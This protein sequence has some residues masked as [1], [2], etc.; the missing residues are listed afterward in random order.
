[1]SL[2]IDFGPMLKTLNDLGSDLTDKKIVQPMRENMAAGKVATVALSRVDTHTMEK[3]VYYRVTAQPDRIVGEVGVTAQAEDGYP[4][5]ARQHEDL[6]LENGPKSE[7]K[8]DYDGMPV[9]PKFLSRPFEKY[10]DK[11]VEN[12]ADGVNKAIEEAMRR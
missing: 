11:F 9:G 7:L 12:L 10:H 3:S 4:Y 8:P 1:M 5:P 6:T 2:E